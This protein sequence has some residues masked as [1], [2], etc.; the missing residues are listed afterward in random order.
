MRAMKEFFRV[1]DL[2]EARARARGL[3]AVGRERVSLGAALGRVLARDLVA[4]EDLPG[5]ARSTMDG[6]AVQAASTFGASDSSPA[7]LGVVG[8]VEMGAIASNNPPIPP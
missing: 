7:L 2:E 3:S 6:Y 1:V 5:F 4:G 8:S